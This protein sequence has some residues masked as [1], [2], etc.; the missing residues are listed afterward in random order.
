[1]LSRICPPQKCEAVDIGGHEGPGVLAPAEAPK[2]L[3]LTFAGASDE[4]DGGAK[5]I[6][7]VLV[8]PGKFRI[9]TPDG[10]SDW[11]KPSVEVEFTQPFAERAK[12]F[13]DAAWFVFWRRAE[14]N[15]KFVA[16]LRFHPFVADHGN[17]HLR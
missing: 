16:I 12:C 10:D 9:G 3:R 8:P 15:Q 14:A 17:D 6:E 1:M 2:M 13:P 5:P 7:I 11:E 4:M